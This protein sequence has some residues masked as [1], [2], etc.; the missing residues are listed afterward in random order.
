MTIEPGY[1]NP[2]LGFVGLSGPPLSHL[3]ILAQLGEDVHLH[4]E[5]TVGVRLDFHHVLCVI[6][7]NLPRGNINLL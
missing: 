6:S 2:A 7:N 3:V 4:E 5:R 1:S